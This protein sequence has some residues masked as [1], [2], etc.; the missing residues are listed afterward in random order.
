MNTLKKSLI[1]GSLA[2]LAGAGCVKK[3]VDNPTVTAPTKAEVH[4][5]FH[6]HFGSDELAL[7]TGT[8][9]N[10]HGEQLKIT[11]FDYWITNIKLI[12]SDGTEYA[13]PESYRLLRGND[14]AATGHFH[15]EDVPAGTYTGVK[16][17]MG[18]DVARNTS[19]AQTGAL[20]PA[21]CTGMYWDWS[22]GYIQAKMEGTSPQSTL[23]GNMISYHIAGVQ[24]GYESPREVTLTFPNNMVIGEKAGS[25][26][27]KADAAKWFGPTNNIKIADMPTMTYAGA[28]AVKFADNIKGMFSIES[29]GN[30]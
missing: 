14:I 7:N 10:M 15:V 17:T 16:F 28:N 13:E 11:I 19:G 6:N 2:I 26:E 3:P 18:V 4:F 12:K 27:V 25:I 20:D 9:T 22:T 23:T 8:Y 5:N 1:A 30:E 21:V 24:P 29:V